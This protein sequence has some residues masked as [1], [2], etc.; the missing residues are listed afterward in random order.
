MQFEYGI[1]KVASDQYYVSI[2]NREYWK[3]Q[4]CG[5]VINADTVQESVSITNR[6]YWKLQCKKDMAEI[7]IFVF[8]SLIGSIGNCNSG[9]LKAYLYLVF[10][11][12]LRE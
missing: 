12:R 4:E 2:H 8:Q 1:E 7:R 6:E 3:L 5:L 10:K 11:V 9:I